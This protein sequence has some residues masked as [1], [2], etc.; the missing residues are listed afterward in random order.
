MEY[1]GI[2]KII[3]DGE[4]VG[5]I[6]VYMQGIKIVFEG[7]CVTERQGPFRLAAVSG[8]RTIPVGVMLPDGGKFTFRRSFSKN[9]MS[10]LGIGEIEEFLLVG[11]DRKD[12]ADYREPAAE[13]GGWQEA[14]EP[15]RLFADEELSEVCREVKGGLK[16]LEENGEISFAVPLERDRPFPAMPIFCFGTYMKIGEKGYVVFRL[17]NGELIR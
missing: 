17:K 15:W 6:N 9:M 8:G 7:E 1:G 10:E 4:C 14:A 2:I 5:E 16:R 12:M 3:D 11:N 13:A